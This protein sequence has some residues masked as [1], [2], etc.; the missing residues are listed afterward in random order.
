MPLLYGNNIMMMY[1]LDV[2]VHDD[3]RGMKNAVINGSII[4]IIYKNV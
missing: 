2:R 3:M 4:I 1:I